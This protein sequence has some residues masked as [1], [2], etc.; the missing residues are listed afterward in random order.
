M[1]IDHASKEGLGRVLMQYGAMVS[2]KSIKLKDHEGRYA[3]HELK[4]I[5][6]VHNLKV[7]KYYLFREA[8]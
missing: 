2:Y 4:Y 8:F 6:M 1:C 5:V 7:W 3:T